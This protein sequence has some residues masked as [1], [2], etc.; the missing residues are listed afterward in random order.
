[1]YYE[2]SCFHGG[3]EMHCQHLGCDTVYFLTVT[4][5]FNIE[6][7]GDSFFRTSVT[8]YKTTQR[9]NADHK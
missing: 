3:R 4:K 8:T 5:E 1:M 2:I 6:D 7:G 9:H